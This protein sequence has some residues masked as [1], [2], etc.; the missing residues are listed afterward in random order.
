MF[1]VK[2]SLIVDVHKVDAE[3]AKT[4]GVKEGSLLIKHDFV[5]VTSA[6]SEK[7]RD[8]NALAAMKK[9][10]RKVKLIDHLPIPDLD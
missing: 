8:E 9:L 6:E 5:L 4:Y 2:D 3:M 10:G 1:G 7:L